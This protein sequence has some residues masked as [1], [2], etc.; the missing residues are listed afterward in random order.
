MVNDRNMTDGMSKKEYENKFRE[1]V[2]L[3]FAAPAV[4]L[5]GMFAVGAI[6]DNFTHASQSFAY[7]FSGIGGIPAIAYYYVREWKKFINR[8]VPKNEILRKLDE[9]LSL[10]KEKK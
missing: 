8:D 7:L 6:I 4:I 1:I 2:F 5:I 10:L 3:F 9:I